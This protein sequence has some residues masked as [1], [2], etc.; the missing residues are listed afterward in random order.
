MAGDQRDRQQRRVDFEQREKTRDDE[1][2]QRQRAET[3]ERRIAHDRQNPLAIRAAAKA[4]DHVAPAVLVDRSG[5]DDRRSDG[6][7]ER[8]RLGPDQRGGQKT[9]AAMAPIS[10]PTAGK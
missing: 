7:D 3:A 2:R 1:Q 5:D 10:R 4:V 6:G 9:I 8:E